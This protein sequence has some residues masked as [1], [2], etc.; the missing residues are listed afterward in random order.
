MK[1]ACSSNMAKFT[2]HPDI[3]FVSIVNYFLG[4]SNVFLI[5]IFA[6]I[7]VNRRISCVNRSFDGL[8]AFM[9]VSVQDHLVFMIFFKRVDNRNRFFSAKFF[10]KKESLFS[11]ASFDNDGGFGVVGSKKDAFEDFAVAKVK[12]AKGITSFLCVRE[13]FVDERNTHGILSAFWLYKD[14]LMLPKSPEHFQFYSK[15]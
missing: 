11:F 7:N 15:E 8:K 9:M 2:L 4:E 1:S 12:S 14:C 6:R 13:E 3:F 5:V 10:V